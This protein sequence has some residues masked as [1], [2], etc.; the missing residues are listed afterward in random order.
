[1]RGSS[2][3]IAV[4]PICGLDFGEFARDVAR[5][6]H[7]PSANYFPPRCSTRSPG[8]TLLG[9]VLAFARAD[10]TRPAHG[11]ARFRVASA[12]LPD[13]QCWR[14][15]LPRP[16]ARLSTRPPG[17]AG[18][19]PP[20]L[21]LA[22]PGMARDHRLRACQR[23]ALL[24]VVLLRGRRDQSPFAHNSET[25]RWHLTY[26]HL[27]SGVPFWPDNSDLR[28]GQGC[29]LSRRPHLF[30]RCS[31]SPASMLLRGLIWSRD[32]GRRA[33]RHRALAWAGESRS[34]PSRNG[35][36]ADSSSSRPP[37]GSRF[38]N[39]TRLEAFSSRS[40]STAARA[41]LCVARRPASARDWR[42]RFVQIEDR[43]L[44]DRGRA[45]APREPAALHLHT[46]IFLS[47]MLAAWW[48][49]HPPVRRELRSSL[50]P[51]FLPARR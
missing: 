27:A 41:A 5:I 29:D 46:F 20:T 42:A 36:R 22:L 23:R 35:G 15:E 34:L 26:S 48:L 19:R 31:R 12:R 9:T 45:A 18:A 2:G 37:A 1:M 44:G 17:V 51:L 30:M 8:S 50:R 28:A 3:A 21:L 43:R 25:S 38:P 7:P 24:L 16:R 4:P 39:R 40:L 33:H 32:C 49:L 10:G 14:A 47:L 11:R 6:C 13:A